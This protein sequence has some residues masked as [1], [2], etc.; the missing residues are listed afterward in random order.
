MVELNPRIPWVLDAEGMATMISPRWQQITG[1][2]E[3]DYRGRGFI[4]R[5]SERYMTLLFTTGVRASECL[6]PHRPSGRL[7][8]LWRF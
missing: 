7:R 5:V 1:M 8:A 3:E 6:I 2:S 4:L